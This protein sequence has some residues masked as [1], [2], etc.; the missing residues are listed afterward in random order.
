MTRGP[1]VTG[2]ISLYAFFAYC[3][4]IIS[5]VLALRVLVSIFRLGHG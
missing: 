3:L 5:S 4:L 1:S 2:Q